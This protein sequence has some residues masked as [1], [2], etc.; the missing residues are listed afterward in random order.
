MKREHAYKLRELL[1]KA[2][3]SLPDEDALEAVELFPVWAI[4]IAYEVNQR[5]RYG[6]KLYRVVQAHTSLEGWEPPAVPALWTEVAKPGEFPVWKQPIGVQ[7]AYMKGDAV[8]YPTAEGPIYISLCD[9]NTWEP[10]AY[11]WEITH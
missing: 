10:S 3:S 4:G 1:H 7:D 11:G 6:D 5:I 9:Y 2:S 8:H